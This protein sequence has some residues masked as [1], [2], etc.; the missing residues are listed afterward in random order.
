MYD[1][2][3]SLI[4]VKCCF[5]FSFEGIH[6]DRIYRAGNYWAHHAMPRPE[7]G[8]GARHQTENETNQG[9]ICDHIKTVTCRA[10]NYG[11]APRRKYLQSDLS[12][13]KMHRLFLEQNHA[14]VCYSL[15]YSVFFFLTIQ[16]WIW[17]SI[18]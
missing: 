13:A 1:V 8:D 14:Q 11:G 4:N 18:N 12:V 5:I 10:S 3:V 17:P 7:T 15:Y 16:S 6:K 2:N 9:L